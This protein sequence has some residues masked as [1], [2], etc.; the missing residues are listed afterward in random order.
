MTSKAQ[1]LL[2]QQLG[3]LVGRKEAK[4][5]NEIQE[6]VKPDSTEFDK[7][8]VRLHHIQGLASCVTALGDPNGNVSVH[9][10]QDA[11]PAL[12]EVIKEMSEEVYDLTE[13]IWRRAELHRN[14]LAKR[15]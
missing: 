13:K 9:Y 4:M 12:G 14:A 6:S 5:A 8:Q 3:E 2:A 1:K 15:L 11:M 10:L 7:L